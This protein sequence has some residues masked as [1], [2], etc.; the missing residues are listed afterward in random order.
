MLRWVTETQVSANLYQDI[1]I[2]R[3]HSLI[4]SNLLDRITNPHMRI[5]W[6]MLSDDPCESILASPSRTRDD[7]ESR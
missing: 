3:I 7:D 2:I 6:V 4:T 5:L 1:F